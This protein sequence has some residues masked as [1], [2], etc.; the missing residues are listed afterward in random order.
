M[1]DKRPSQQAMDKIIQGEVK[2]VPRWRFV[3]K[4]IALWF[5]GIICVIAGSLTVS[6]IIF[7]VVNSGPIFD[8]IGQRN[9][10]KQLIIILPMLWLL[11]TIIFVILFDILIRRTKR[12]YKYSLTFIMLVNIG[13]SL[14]LGLLFYLF[15]VSYIVD[16]SLGRLKYYNSV[17]KRHAQMFNSPEDG[18]IVGRVVGCTDKY[19][20]L[21]APDGHR[22]NVMNEHID[23]SQKNAMID[24]QIVMVRGEKIDEDIFVA[25]DIRKR[26][27]RGGNNRVQQRHVEKMIHMHNMPEEICE[28][29]HLST[30]LQEY[31]KSACD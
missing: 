7:T 19:F 6:L 21:I 15:G 31:V 20:T 17:E 4:N 24:G 14:L 23:K 26:G 30:E 18:M 12:G 29:K 9:V 2:K 13:F 28:C 11:I 5:V 16:D 10:W 3:V 8:H 22:W 1:S 25:C 27:M